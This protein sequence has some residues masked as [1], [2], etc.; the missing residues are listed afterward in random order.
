MKYEIRTL[1]DIF[2][3]VPADKIELC[4]AEIAASMALS[5]ATSTDFEVPMVWPGVIEWID[6]GKQENGFT[7]T[8]NGEEI[9]TATIK[10]GEK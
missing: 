7:L 3:K 9:L 1:A 5:K 8:H 4:M 6:D 2:N 10:K